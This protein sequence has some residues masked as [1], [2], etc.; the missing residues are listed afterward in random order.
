MNQLLLSTFLITS[1]F[2]AA[3]TFDASVRTTSFINTK[4][5]DAEHQS[6]LS[7]D[8][9]SVPAWKKMPD[10]A[11][12]NSFFLHQR[13]LPQV[14]AAL[15]DKGLVVVFAKGYSFT[16][17][18]EKPMSLPFTYFSDDV[19]STEGYSWQQNIKQG[20]VELQLSV[21]SALDRTFS[22]H[23]DDIQF[24]YFILSPRFFEEKAVTPAQ[25]KSLSYKNFIALLGSSE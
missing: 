22:E 17:M 6:V 1:L 8:W 24:R 11:G 21:P 2:G 3:Q 10:K 15:I 4:T 5:I 7:S 16:A 20:V 12:K 9:E 23:R 13:N 19:S 18:P 25:V 14:D